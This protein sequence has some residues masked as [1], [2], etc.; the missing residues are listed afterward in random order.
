MILHENVDSP[1]TLLMHH[2]HFFSR[3]YWEGWSRRTGF[4]VVAYDAPFHGGGPRCGSFQEFAAVTS[5]DV[6]RYASGPIV[7]V[8]VSQGG[9][10]AQECG[11]FE[12]IDAV[13]GISTTRKSANDV[14]RES[15]SALIDKWGISGCDGDIARAVADRSTNG[16][17]PSRSQTISAIQGMSKYQISHSVPLLLSRRGNIPICKP[18]LFV[19][20]TDDQTYPLSENIDAGDVRI[21]TLAGGSHSVSLQHPQEVADIVRDFVLSVIS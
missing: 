14:E 15:M 20:G 17:E 21:A 12:E 1:I 4:N 7:A 9:V 8:G 13:I 10:I 5:A 18:S 3:L 16:A 19:H 2:P 11:E 6:R